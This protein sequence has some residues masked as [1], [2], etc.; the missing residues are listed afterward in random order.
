MDVLDLGGVRDVPL[1][2]A[3]AGAETAHHERQPETTVEQQGALCYEGRQIHG[4]SVA[5]A[6]AA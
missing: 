4:V 1:L 2:G 6:P 5:D 3:L